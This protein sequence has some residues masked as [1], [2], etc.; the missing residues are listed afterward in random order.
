[1]SDGWRKQYVEEESQQVFGQYL[2]EM[3]FSVDSPDV[4][5]KSSSRPSDLDEC[6]VHDEKSSTEKISPYT[7]KQRE[8]HASVAQ[9]LSLD[10]APT[11]ENQSALKEKQ[12]KLEPNIIVKLLSLFEYI[13]QQY[14]LSIVQHRAFNRIILAI[15]LANTVIL[16]LADYN[17]VDSDNNLLENGSLRNAV[18]IRSE[19]FFVVAFTVEMI[20][21]MLAHGTDR[22]LYSFPKYIY[23]NNDFK[24]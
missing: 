3:I 24:I 12:G 9:E 10:V 19:I 15:I 7:S 4:T 13:R 14:L 17:Y 8:V 11:S 6:L 5:I 2:S 21:K 18:L 23:C 20:M 16:S 22:R 1:M